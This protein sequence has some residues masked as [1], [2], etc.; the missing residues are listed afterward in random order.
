MRG[1]RKSVRNKEALDCVA[2]QRE[3]R[4]ALLIRVSTSATPCTVGWQR[5][6]LWESTG[7]GLHTHAHT[8]SAGGPLGKQRVMTL[9]PQS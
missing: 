9:S 3:M 8:L 6:M 4:G 1:S 2:F 5:L 7:S